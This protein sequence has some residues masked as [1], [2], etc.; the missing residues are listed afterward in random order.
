MAKTGTREA[1]PTSKD[2]AGHKRPRITKEERRK[3]YVEIARQRRQKQHDQ[4]RKKDVVC[5]HCRQNGHFV[6][7]CP[8]KAKSELETSICYKCG[9]TEHALS[10]CPKKNSGKATDLPFATCFLCKEKGHLASKCPKNTKG[11]YI[12]G[13][14]C[15]NCGSRDHLAS[16]CP[17]AKKSKAKTQETD[18]SDDV[19]ELLEPDTISRETKREPAATTERKRRVVKF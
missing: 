15:R 2:V 16:K 13:G 12:N 14:E 1:S 8:S 10:A 5:Y 18:D 17:N 3:K 4:Q 9:S 6:A 19:T 7:D 11:V